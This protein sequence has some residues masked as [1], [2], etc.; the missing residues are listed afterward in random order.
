M[1]ADSKYHPLNSEI[2]TIN[3]FSK[4]LLSFFLILLSISFTN[5]QV[6]V[7]SGGNQW[8]VDS[9]NANTTV[10]AS[11]IGNLSNYVA[12]SGGTTINF[13]FGMNNGNNQMTPGC[14]NGNSSAQMI[15]TLLVNGVEYW[16]A[17][18]PADGNTLSGD[19][20]TL[21]GASFVYGSGNWDMVTNCNGN[22]N[23]GISGKSGQINHHF[24][25]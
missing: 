18:S 1:P 7:L 2:F 15:L 4:S 3:L 25:V 6:N 19:N 23:I 14:C 12:L 24:P 11:Y 10:T 20:T 9:E 22:Q 17:T 21:G 13:R 8:F 16:R 5:A